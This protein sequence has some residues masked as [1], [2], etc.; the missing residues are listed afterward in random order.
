MQRKTVFVVVLL[1]KKKKTCAASI[2]KFC[3]SMS[4]LRGFNMQMKSKSDLLKNDLWLCLYI[5]RER[6]EWN[7]NQKEI[8]NM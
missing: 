5:M 8:R 6:L 2:S 7:Q 3:F 4:K 1:K